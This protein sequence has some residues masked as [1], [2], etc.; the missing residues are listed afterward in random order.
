LLLYHE[1]MMPL[2]GLSAWALKIYSRY[3]F[4]TN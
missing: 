2:Y 3:Y 1:S 4:I